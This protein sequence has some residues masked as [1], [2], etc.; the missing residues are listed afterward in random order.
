MS[1]KIIQTKERLIT[2]S[3]VALVGAL[4]KKTSLANFSNRLGKPKDVKHQNSN[5]LISYVGLLCQG[6]TVY[7]D[8][9]EMQEDPSFF[10][11]ALQVNSIP[12]A[13]TLRQRL[14]YLG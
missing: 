5:C 7:D 3:G 4:L 6:K 14:D 10:S 1:L 13:E 8:I 12:S 2:P 11:Q 9:R